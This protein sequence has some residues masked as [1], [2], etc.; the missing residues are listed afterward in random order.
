MSMSSFPR[1]HWI[2][3]VICKCTYVENPERI[4]LQSWKLGWWT[5]D[6]GPPLSA[7]ARKS[8]EINKKTAPPHSFPP[9]RHPFPTTPAWTNFGVPDLHAC[10]GHTEHRVFLLAGPAPACSHHR[11]R[12]YQ[13]PLAAG[14]S[15]QLISS[16]NH[17]ARLER[18][19]SKRNAPPAMAPRQVAAPR[20][21][22]SSQ[23]EGQMYELGVQGR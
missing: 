5:P 11:H 22:Q 14:H 15:R 10:R 16:L 20:R 21:T 18:S 9:K 4:V 7:Y 2:H 17:T 1:L 19:R 6:R 8:D 23:N 12:P 13:L 3:A